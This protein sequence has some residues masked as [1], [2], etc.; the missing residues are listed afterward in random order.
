MNQV[1]VWLLYVL[2]SSKI[3]RCETVFSNCILKHPKTK[4]MY[5]ILVFKTLTLYFLETYLRLSYKKEQ[6]MDLP[7]QIIGMLT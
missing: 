1:H 7:A 2:G 5:A 4:Y 6:T 3:K